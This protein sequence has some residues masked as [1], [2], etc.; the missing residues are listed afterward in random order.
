MLFDEFMAGT[1]C[2]D[3]DYN[4]KVYMDL[5]ILYMNSDITKEK[6]YEYGKKLVDN[7]LTP[8]QIEW[9]KEVDAKIAQAQEELQHAKD[10]LRLDE[11]NYEYWK[12]FDADYA[13]LLKKSIRIDRNDIK[14]IRAYIR[15][16]KGFKYTE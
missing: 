12:N 2:K 3:N 13:K 1:G 9:N 4:L 5:N 11:D 6:I 14:R 8:S 16:M 15:E 7:S 10:A